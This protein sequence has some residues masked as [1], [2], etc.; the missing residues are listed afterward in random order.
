MKLEKI[1]IDTNVL[2]SAIRSKNGASYKLIM[3]LTNKR[4]T[5]CLSVP[6]FVEYESVLKRE[7]ITT[8][9]THNDIDNILDFFLSK[10]DIRSI[11]YLWRPF[12][13][14]PKDDMVLELAVESDSKYI[15]TYNKRDFTGIDKFGITALSPLE[16]INK[17]GILL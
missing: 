15:I 5:P 16:F 7:S 3:E 1:V 12:L 10:S 13:K 8:K 6:L 14:D 11:F 4:Y 9:L 17:K 2:V